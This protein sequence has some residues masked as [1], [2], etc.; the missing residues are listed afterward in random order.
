MTINEFE[1]KLKYY[2]YEVSSYTITSTEGNRSY[3]SWQWFG[4]NKKA[5]ISYCFNHWDNSISQQFNRTHD[6]VRFNYLDNSNTAFY[7]LDCSYEE[8]IEEMFERAYGNA[9]LIRDCRDCKIKEILS[10]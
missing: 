4:I 1:I 3:I 6:R 7:V 10:E 5:T 8:C 2:G 9:K